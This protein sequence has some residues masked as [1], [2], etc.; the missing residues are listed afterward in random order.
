[1][2]IAYVCPSFY[3]ISET[4]VRDLANGLSGMTN[5]TI[6]TFKKNVLEVGG[7]DLK[8]ELIKVPLLG[9]LL[10]RLLGGV[11][12]FLPSKYRFVERYRLYV[13]SIVCKRKIINSK[14]DL[15]YAEFGTFG[16]KVLN[17]AEA[18]DVPL[19]VHFH[20]AD[21]SAALASGFYVAQIKKL[22]KFPKSEII[23]PSNHL[24]RRLKISCGIAKNFY[25]I[26]CFPKYTKPKNRGETGRG[27]R[28]VAAV[29]RMVEKKSP[30]T[31]LEAFSIV[32][33]MD[34]D[35]VLNYVGDGP[36][37]KQVKQRVLELGIGQNVKLLGALQH[38]EVLEVIASSSVF[39]QHSV[40]ASNGD[41]EGLPVAILEAL[42]MNI[43]V[44]STIH[45]GIPEVVFDGENGY[46]V[47]EFDYVSMAEYI[48]L[49]L[50][51]PSNGWD[52]SKSDEMLKNDRLA[53]IYSIFEDLVGS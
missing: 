28:Q 1:M 4:F 3:P 6:Y 19:V 39:V 30:L 49:A 36:L 27:V 31:L 7:V 34:P 18:L 23:V 24:A 10:G 11:E 29:G 51:N 46:L 21:A 33:K 43:P 9:R 53:R 52:F 47:R 44:V 17:V 32:C 12:K 48:Q 38:E 5:L 20:G 45:S 41:Q 15:I 37:F 25:V 2:K 16:V 13:D 42:K 22:F 35:V 14:P 40:T 26:P 8:I 50:L